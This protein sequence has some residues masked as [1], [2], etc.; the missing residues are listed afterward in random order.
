MPTAALAAR[1]PPLAGVATGW[2]PLSRLSGLSRL[3]SG[4]TRLVIGL[5]F[6]ARLA[7]LTRLT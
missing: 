6:L 2:I 3:T 1:L 4:L 5:A 7:L